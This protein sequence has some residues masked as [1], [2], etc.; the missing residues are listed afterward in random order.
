MYHFAQAQR[1]NDLHLLFEGILCMEMNRVVG[2]LV[3]ADQSLSLSNWSFEF[4]NTKLRASISQFE[5]SINLL[6][7]TLN[8]IL[9][10]KCNF[11]TI[12]TFYVLI[13]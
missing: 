7:R 13:E 1:S 8:Y 4:A 10:I 3:F 11:I 9:P 5:N 6:L 2:C 12:S